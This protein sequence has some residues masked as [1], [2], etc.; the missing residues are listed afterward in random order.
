M[1]CAEC[2]RAIA[3]AKGESLSRI[4]CANCQY[5]QELAITPELEEEKRTIFGTFRCPECGKS[6]WTRNTLATHRRDHWFR[7]QN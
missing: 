5:A 2:L 6:C 4:A 3:E 7:R 1:T